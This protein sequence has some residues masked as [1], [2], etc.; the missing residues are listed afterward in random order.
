MSGEIH[1]LRPGPPDGRRYGPDDLEGILGRAMVVQARHARPPE[2][3]DGPSA[4]QAVLEIGRVMGVGDDHLNRAF[5]AEADDAAVRRQWLERLRAQPS[6]WAVAGRIRDRVLAAAGPGGP[7]HAHLSTTTHDLRLDGVPGLQSR[8]NAIRHVPAVRVEF[9]DQRGLTFNFLGL[10]L[11]WPRLVRRAELF[12][13]EH[14][15]RFLIDGNL[16]D[17]RMV[18]L[19]GPVVAELERD[20]GD[21]ISIGSVRVDEL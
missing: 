17:L 4:R 1:P 5:D 6:M 11:R 18:D 21:R 10:E 13:V 2:G 15:Q 14:E 9:S 12:V 19:I 16:V 7:H 8:L 20:F 3:L